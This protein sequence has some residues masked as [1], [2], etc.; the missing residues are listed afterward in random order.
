MVN[1]S[2]RLYMELRGWKE[3]DLYE[4]SLS[5]FIS[6][7]FLSGLMGIA[8]LFRANM[9]L[10]E[11]LRRAQGELE[12][13]GARRTGPRLAAANEDLQTRALSCSIRSWIISRT[14][15]TSRTPKD[16]LSASTRRGPT[17]QFERSV[18]G[19][20]QVG[21][22]FLHRRA[23]LQARTTGGKA[24]A[25]GRDGQQG[26]KETWP[27][28]RT[29][30]ASATKVPLLDHAGQIVGSLGI[31]QDIAAQ[32]LEAE[33]SAGRQR[34]GRS[35][36]PRQERFPGQHEPRNPH[37]DEWRHRHDRTGARHASSSP[38]S[39]NISTR[40]ASRASPCCR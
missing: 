28:G 39:A 40:S 20:R 32:K 26:G 15:S 19:G 12:R 1:R 2:F 30:W 13:R 33:A 11:E 36:Q 23:R 21:F 8:P 29:T 27:D 9:R 16:A 7:L 31:S 14:I 37:A 34:N 35:R 17:R 18:R 24:C 3:T 38:S 22:Q 10:A 5:L 4:E 6:M 25:P